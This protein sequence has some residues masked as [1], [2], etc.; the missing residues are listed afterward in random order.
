MTSKLSKNTTITTLGQ[1]KSSFA[2]NWILTPGIVYLK[3][4]ESENTTVPETESQIK[5]FWHRYHV[6][7]NS[8]EL[9]LTDYHGFDGLTTSSNDLETIIASDGAWGV[10]SFSE[11]RTKTNMIKIDFATNESQVLFSFGDQATTQLEFQIILSI[12]STGSQVWY[13]NYSSI[14]DATQVK[15]QLQNIDVLTGRISHGFVVH[16]N[17]LDPGIVTSSYIIRADTRGGGGLFGFI[18]FPSEVLVT[19]LLLLP[20]IRL[21]TKKQ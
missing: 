18:I 6:L 21:K 1:Y 14:G 16:E 8:S 7:E 2:N 19:V 10:I 4:I 17:M 12:A 3:S 13:L 15:Y 11:S 20:V 5:L 9:I